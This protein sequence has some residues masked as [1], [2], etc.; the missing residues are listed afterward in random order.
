M[1]DGKRTPDLWSWIFDP[2]TIACSPECVIVSVEAKF[3]TKN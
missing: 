2:D 1:V 3:A